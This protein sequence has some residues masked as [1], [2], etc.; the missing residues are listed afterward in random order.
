MNVILDLMLF[1]H[2]D[3]LPYFLAAS[4]LAYYTLVS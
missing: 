3:R 2:V 4:M 1:V